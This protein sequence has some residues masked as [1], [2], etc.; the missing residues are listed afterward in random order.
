MVMA[1]FWEL[2]T[3]AGGIDENGKILSPEYKA[4]V[5]TG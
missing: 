1:Y 4:E 3:F 2:S 5:L